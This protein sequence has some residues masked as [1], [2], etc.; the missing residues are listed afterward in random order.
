[1]SSV[2]SFRKK[3]KVSVW[4]TVRKPDM[5]GM[6]ILKDR[7]G[8]EY[9]DLDNQE[10]SAVDETLPKADVEDVL[11]RLSYS[12][13]FLKAALEAAAKKKVTKVYS[14]LAQYD[15]AYKPGKSRPPVAAEAIQYEVKNM[16]RKGQV[17]GIGKG[18]IRGQ[19]RFVADL[20][21]VAA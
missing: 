11:A 8:V 6:D 16:I 1:M 21:K 4:V 14:A 15:F 17:E 5:K 3:G 12:S 20:F 10:V 18:D 9:H 19:V 13:S 7:C 2:P